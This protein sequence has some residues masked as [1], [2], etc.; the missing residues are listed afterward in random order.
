MGLDEFESL[1]LK[2]RG[3]LLHSIYYYLGHDTILY[4]KVMQI[5][6]IG[7]QLFPDYKIFLGL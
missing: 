1:L 2:T 5:I 4:A 7:K 6:A 3:E